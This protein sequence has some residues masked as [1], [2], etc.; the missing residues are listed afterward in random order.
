MKNVGEILKN[1][2]LEK[3]LALSEAQQA[4]KIKKE[5]LEAIERND[6]QKI[7]SEVAARGFIK[8]YAEFLGLSSKSVLAVFKRDFIQGKR[9]TIIPYR[10][11]FIWTPKLTMI[12]VVVI[13]TLLLVAYLSWQ[14]LSLVSTPYH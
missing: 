8:N 3:K 9:E 7:S 12:L 10:S 4:T 11:G 14:Y 6:F 13:F 2:R 1:K 5:F